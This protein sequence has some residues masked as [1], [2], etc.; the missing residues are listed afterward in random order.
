MIVQYI[1][2]ISKIFCYNLLSKLLFI[3]MIRLSCLCGQKRW[4]NN[5]KKISSVYIWKPSAN[6]DFVLLEVL[7]YI[8]LGLLSLRFELVTVICNP[9]MPVVSAKVQKTENFVPS[10]LYLWCN[11]RLILITC[12]LKSKSPS[13]KQ[14]LKPELYYLGR[15]RIKQGKSCRRIITTYKP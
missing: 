10:S 8:Y 7:K 9:L 2:L 12:R 13:G 15:R 6:T 4:E 14:H 11:L 5:F 1:V 3:C